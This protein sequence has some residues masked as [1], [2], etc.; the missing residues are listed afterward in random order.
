ML[1]TLLNALLISVIP[2]VVILIVGRQYG[3]QAKILT[4][5]FVTTILCGGVYFY[6]IY[7]G[8][9]IFS[10]KI[11]KA[12]F[13]FNL[14]LLPHYLSTMV[15]NQ[16]DRIMIDRMVGPSEAGIYSVAYSAAMVLSILISAIN[17]SYAPWIYRK[18]ERREYVG[19]ASM[20]NEMFA[21]I[22]LVLV[23]LIS[24]APECI[25]LLAGEK[26]SEAIKIIP[27]VAS[28]L[29]FIFMY[30]I[31]AN[32]EFFY[33]KNEFIA[34]ASMSGAVLNILLNY[35]GINHFGYIAA[36]Y[37]TLICYVLFGTAHY[38][39]MRRICKKE[40]PGVCLFEVRAIF[41]FGAG[42]IVVALG[43][44]LLYDYWIVRY[45][46][47]AVA[48]VVLFVHSRKVKNIVNVI[49]ER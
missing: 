31:F 13:L 20:A 22:G 9:C 44:S 46:V 6:L 33:K 21:D 12:A 2:I 4:Q 37:T 36:G 11:W 25:A 27:P 16:A 24:F 19:V 39:F 10:R 18:L 14:P 47:F 43:I 32:V 15:L 8:K 49:K 28:S 35:I 34:Y 45:A 7:K 3:A 30:Q 38:C 17:N 29:Y 41:L 48:A 42:L 40:M 5:A 26:Y 1:I 23:M